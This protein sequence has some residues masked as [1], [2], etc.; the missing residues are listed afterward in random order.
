MSHKV[1]V[2]IPN[3]NYK[4]YLAQRIESVLSQTY[5]DFEIIL[6]DDKST[7]GSQ[8][9]LRSYATNPKVTH[10]ILNE[11]NTG[12]PFAQWEKGL[13]V[14]KGEYIW[15]AESD[16]YASSTFLEETVKALDAN[17]NAVL[18][19]T[20]SQFVDENGTY[21]DKDYDR[22][23][24]DDS[25]RTYS[26]HHYIKHHL[27]W[28]NDVYNASMVLFRYKDY[29]RIGKQF[30]RMRYCADWLFW[31]EMASLGDVI[32]I[33]KRLNFFR[34]HSSRVTKTSEGSAQR[35]SELLDIQQ[36]IWDKHPMGFYRL[37]LA[38]GRMYKNIHRLSS[39]GPEK[40]QLLLRQEECR[41]TPLHFVFERII[42]MLHQ[43]MPCIKTP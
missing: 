36:Y 31:I 17:A 11:E 19:A 38:K 15:I 43:L 2:I 4:R 26:S 9:V 32:K 10:C 12:S 28:G 5:Q 14:A 37:W 7:D 39:N 34:Q 6:L 20:C 27:Y 25:V 33:H 13:S 29:E 42:K 24:L 3:Y 22:V 1:S 40:Q 23:K 35:I 21:M 16:D 30:T 8:E 41:I 18:A